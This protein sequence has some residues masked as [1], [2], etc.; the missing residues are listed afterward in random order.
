LILTRK[1]LETPIFGAGAFLLSGALVMIFAS[2]NDMAADGD[3]R[4]EAILALF[5]FAVFC[6]GLIHFRRSCYAAFQNPALLALLFFTCLSAMWAELPTVVLRRAIGVAG[7]SLFGI[8]VGAQLSSSEQLRMLRW[9]LRTAAALSLAMAIVSPAHGIS[10]SMEGGAWRGIF[11]HKN[12]LGSAMALGILVEWLLPA[13]TLPLKISKG[14]WLSLLVV[15]LALSNSITAAV[16]I[17]LA[18]ATLYAF[19]VFHAQYKVPLPAFVT[20]SVIVAG[21]LLAYR[22]PITTALGRSSDIT[23]RTE[24]WQWVATMIL[25]HPWLGYGFS[26][27][28]RGGSSEYAYV[29]RVI[30]WSPVYS[31]DGYLEILLSLG[32]VGFLLFVWLIGTGLTRAVKH[33]RRG[34]SIYDLWPLAFLIYFLI[35]NLGESTILWQNCLEWALCIA[36]IVATDPRLHGSAEEVVPEPEMTLTAATEQI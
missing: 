19:R 27:F 17:F 1:I 8:V 26:G 3:R 18:L 33:A 22:T 13:R 34:R 6:I 20:G 4:F 28:W 2:G 16:A 29:E 14:L 36:A 32:V 25:R 15:L 10:S 23:G 31:H 7:T 12:A 35:H 5:Y 9:V 11:G 21:L 24:L 30:G